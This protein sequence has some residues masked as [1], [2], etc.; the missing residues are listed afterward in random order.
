MTG[1]RCGNESSNEKLTIQAAIIKILPPRD[2]GAKWSS[3]LYTCKDAATHSHI[4][5]HDGQQGTVNLIDHQADGVVVAR[6]AVQS[7]IHA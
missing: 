7:E 5:H 6:G 1:V 4:S 3:A 2:A